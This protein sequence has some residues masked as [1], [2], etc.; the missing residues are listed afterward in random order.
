MRDFLH[1][2]GRF[3]WRL[4]R[5]ALVALVRLYQLAISPWLPSACRFT[6]SCSAYAI[7]ALREYGFL[8]GTVLAGW[9]ILR[10]NP[11]GGHGHDPPR[12]FGEGAPAVS[13]CSCPAEDVGAIR[14]VRPPAG[15][16]SVRLALVAQAERSASG[17]LE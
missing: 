9:R 10:C 14:R 12:W 1:T 2:A 6:P 16:E 7:I 3:L 11:W 17:D 15:D 4:P 8:R 13:H 5:L